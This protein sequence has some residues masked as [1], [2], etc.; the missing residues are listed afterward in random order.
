VYTVFKQIDKMTCTLLLV[1]FC[2][3]IFAAEPGSSVKVYQTLVRPLI[4]KHCIQCHGPDKPKGEFRIDTLGAKLHEGE[5][6][7]FWHEVL[8]QLNEGEMPPEGK[9]QLTKQE[10]TTFTS[11]LESGL[12]QAAAKRSSSGGRQM[13]RRMSRYEY[14]YTLQ[15]LLGI[16]LDYTS[17][18]PGDFSG[19]DGLMTNAK[20]LGMSPVLMQGYMEVALMALDEAI[21][22]GP[23]K[24][25]KATTTKYQRAKIRGQRQVGMPRR[26]KGKPKP[27]EPP[28]LRHVLAPS[29]GFKLSRFNYDLPGKVT[30]D[31]RPFAG[32]FAIRARVKAFAASDG[33]L[34]E[35]TI[36]IGHRASGDYDPKKVIGSKMVQ[37]SEE[38]QVI[39]FLGNIEDFP[40]GKK[41]GYYNGSGSH[42]VTHLSAWV[43][44]TAKPQ[45]EYTRQTPIEEV[46]EP[47]LHL[48]SVEFEGPLLEGYPS[49][50]ARKL[51]PPRPANLDEAT[52]ARQVL[53]TFIR[54][55]FRREVDPRELEN[56][57]A[58]LKL[59]QGL[60]ADPTDAMRKTMASLL[61]SPKFLYLVEPASQ[62]NKA[63]K[64]NPFEL[65]TR[66]SYFLWAS[67]PDDELLALAADRTLLQSN[68]LKQ[69]V[70]RMRSDSRFS[71]FARHFSHQWLGLPALENVAV[72]P[73]KYPTFSDEIREALKEE[74]IAF[75]EHLFTNDLSALGFVRSEFA[76]LNNTLAQHYGINGIH[77]SHFRPVKLAVGTSRGGLLTQGSILLMGSDGTESNPIY[78]GVWLRKRLFADPPPPPP[79][80]APPLEKKDT[81]KLSLK[82]QIALHRENAS[83]ARCH[84]KIDPWGI[85][86][87]AFDATGRLKSTSFDAATILPGG[88]QVDGLAGL[89]DYIVDRKSRDFANA[90]VRR[91]TGYALG[92]QLEYSDDPLIKQLTDRLIA[93]EFRTSTLFE[94]IVTSPTFLT[95]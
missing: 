91:I 93:N 22:D 63:R 52:H 42:N 79:P 60:T 94:D 45:K 90:L 62:S 58:T 66:L 65:A 89:Q 82:E 27:K 3:P 95:K 75:A 34:P 17:H 77:G 78:R 69:Q 88:V 48:V 51:L 81:S 20:H 43:W 26:E 46:D 47:L 36:Q 72:N 12:Q 8:D 7:G 54:H 15:D 67:M 6:A 56:A 61:V 64:L 32:R 21:P 1:L 50:T 41:D 86:F 29:P 5:S 33:R 80:G 59:F 11:W 53:A 13:M 31:E 38:E 25:F 37:A 19:Q 55:A 44:N 85:A 28:I 68:V 23:E 71:R 49:E 24:V 9:K 57:L 18:I 73:R 16:S 14:Q 39:E 30:F 35:L 87:E 40:L 74:T 70:V 83:C 4:Q 76:L 92:R 84:D 2:N 10:L